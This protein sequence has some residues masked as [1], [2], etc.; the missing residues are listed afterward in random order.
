METIGRF[1]IAKQ[2]GEGDAIF[3][4]VTHQDVADAI[5]VQTNMPIDRRGITLPD[6][7]EIGFYKAQVKIHPEVVAEVEVQ[8]VPA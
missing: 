3:G 1:K 6:I 5:Q 2:V 7:N 4:T 8:V